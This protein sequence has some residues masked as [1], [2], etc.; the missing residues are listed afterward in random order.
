MRMRSTKQKSSKTKL[1]II[2]G[3]LLAVAIVAATLFVLRDDKTT[4]AA[5]NTDNGI[6]YSPATEEEKADSDR[7]KEVDAGRDDTPQ[8]NNVTPVIVDAKQYGGEIEV[9]AYVPGIIEDGGACTITITKGQSTVVRRTEG[10]QDATNTN[11]GSIA[12]PR[13]EFSSAGQW[14]VVVSYSSAKYS[15]SSQ[16]VTLEVQ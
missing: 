6:D 4:P 11:C 10:A 14:S 13:S 8:T 3:I 15:G 5:D 1:W 9:R 2:G 16:A 12:I 7:Q